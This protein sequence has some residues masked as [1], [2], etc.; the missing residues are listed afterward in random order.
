MKDKLK[1]TYYKPDKQGVTCLAGGYSFATEADH[2]KK[3]GVLLYANDGSE[4]RI[5][6][7]ENGKQGTRIHPIGPRAQEH[8]LFGVLHVLEGLG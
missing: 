3:C 2:N 7:S 8:H 4:V 6:F 1:I 5:P